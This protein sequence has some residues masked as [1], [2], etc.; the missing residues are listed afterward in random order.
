MS[1]TRMR[2]PASQPPVS[3]ILVLSSAE[4][5]IMWDMQFDELRS[6]MHPMITHKHTRG[7]CK[8]IKRSLHEPFS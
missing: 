8:K 5:S 4:S 2:V 7:G 3:E 6:M 1:N